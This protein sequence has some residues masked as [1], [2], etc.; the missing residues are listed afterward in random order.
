[1][2]RIFLA[3]ALALLA[4]ARV[5]SAHDVPNDVTVRA[6]LRPEGTRLRFVVRVPLEA[7][8]DVDVPTRGLIADGRLL[9]EEWGRDAVKVEGGQIRGLELAPRSGRVFADPSRR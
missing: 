6:F 8:R 5:A 7:M 4:C 9:S 2:T 1:M 3:A